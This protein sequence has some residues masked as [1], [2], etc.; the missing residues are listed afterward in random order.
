MN[1]HP[2]RR[3]FY[4]G[5]A[6]L[7]GLLALGVWIA[8][9]AASAMQ[10]DP[11]TAAW[12]KARALGS[13]HFSSNVTQMTIPVASVTNVGRQS[14]TDQ[15]RLEGE[16]NLREKRLEMQ[17]WS[18]GGSILQSANEIAINMDERSFVL[19]RCGG[20]HHSG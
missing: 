8:P 1:L 9:H 16:T 18:E 19:A 17:L 20:C 7:A 15:L 5:L 2:Y 10:P 4:L 14:R 13:Y 12:E 3:N 6:L 11:V